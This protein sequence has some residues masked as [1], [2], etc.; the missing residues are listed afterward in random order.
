MKRKQLEEIMKQNSIFLQSEVEYA[1]NFVE[2]MLYA[3][4][5]ETKENEPY[6]TKSIERMESAA[7]E[8]R[9]LTYV[10]W[11]AMEEDE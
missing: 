5:D 9:D 1:I 4:A 2:D 6:A 7:R 10:I 11:E 3:L 8:V